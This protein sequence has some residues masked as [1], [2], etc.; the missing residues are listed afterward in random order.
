M[1]SLRVKVI[2]G[3]SGDLGLLPLVY[4]IA[5]MVPGVD[6]EPEF[7]LMEEE[8]L[9][10]VNGVRIIYDASTYSED[11]IRALIFKGTLGAAHILRREDGGSTYFLKRDPSMQDGALS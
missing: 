1:E 7:D 9:V 10:E 2:Y 6:V 4:S 11:V 3:P 8:A 5:K